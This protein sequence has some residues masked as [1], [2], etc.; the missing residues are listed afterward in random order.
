[1]FAQFTWFGSTFVLM[2][3]TLGMS[4]GQI[5]LMLSLIPFGGLVALFIG[6][7]VA[8]TGYKR[9]FIIFYALRKASTALLL[10]TP[11]V[12]A[13]FGQQAMVVF[14]IGVATALALTKSVAETGYFPG[15]R[16]SSPAPCWAA[17]PPLIACIR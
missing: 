12:L 8:R 15:I 10:L 9:T 1:M 2:L 7:A 14:V 3:S 4:K 17:I 16:S 11:W 5:G 6:T 13:A